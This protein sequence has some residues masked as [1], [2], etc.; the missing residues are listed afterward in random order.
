MTRIG[1]VAAGAVL[2]LLLFACS[3]PLP[4]ERAAPPSPPMPIATP[5]EAAPT[6]TTGEANSSESRKEES[7][8]PLIRGTAEIAYTKPVTKVENSIVV[9]TFRIR[10]RSAGAIAG[11]KC[12][13]YWW[14]KAGNPVTGSSAR[15]KTRLEPGETATLT[16]E[17][18][19]KAGMYQCNYRFSHANGAIKAVVADRLE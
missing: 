4:A 6:D 5:A 16:L 19:K 7:F 3:R 1:T 10:N 14:D 9:T 15:M 17:T 18:P 12:E 2:A 8:V 11:L 13:E